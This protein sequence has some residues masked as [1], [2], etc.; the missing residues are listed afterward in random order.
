MKI[1]KQRIIGRFIM[2]LYCASAAPVIEADGP[3][4]MNFRA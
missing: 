1:Y 4:I 2:D 3:G